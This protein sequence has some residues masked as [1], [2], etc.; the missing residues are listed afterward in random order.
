VKLGGYFDVGGTA[1]RNDDRYEVRDNIE[2]KNL[3]LSSTRLKPNKSTSGHS[4]LGQEEVYL[5]IIG[6]GEMEVGDDRFAVHAGDIVLI[7]DGAFHRVHAGDYGC[8]FVCVFDGARKE[9]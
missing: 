8:Y 1:I 7:P 2:L 4:H 3:V 9:R 5:F 6:S